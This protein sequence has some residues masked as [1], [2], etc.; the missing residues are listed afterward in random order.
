MGK[1]IIALDEGTTSCRSLVI[2]KHGTIVSSD[3]IEVSL[4]TPKQ[5]WVEQDALEIWSLQRTALIQS[6]NKAGINGSEIESIGI[7]NQRETVVV[8]DRMTGLPV[9]NAIIWQDRR[10]SKQCESILKEHGKLI[11]EKTGLIVSPYFSATKVRWI[12]ENVPNGVER[13]ERGELL[14]GTVNTWLIYKLTDSKSFLTDVTNASRTMLFNIHTNDWDDELLEIFK[15]PRA[16]LPTVKKNSDFFGKTYSSLISKTDNTRIP[17]TAS[18]GDQHASLFGHL[19]LD[20]GDAKVTYGTGCFILA[21]TGTKPII[22]EKGLLTTIAFAYG[23]DTFYA[24]EGSVMVAGAAL[25][26][27]KDDLKLIYSLEETEWYAN[28][29]VQQENLYVVPAFTGL[30]SPYWDSSARGAIIG[31]DFGTKREQLIT[32]FIK[33]I[34]YQANDVI[35]AMKSEMKLDFDS[36]KVDGGVIKNNFIMQFQADISQAEI[37]R[38]EN[39]EASAMGAAFLAGLYTGFW[40][41]IA[42]IKTTLS[43]FTT[44]HP[45]RKKE[46]VKKLLRGWKRAV[47]LTFNWLDEDTEA[48]D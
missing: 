7:T 45:M 20:E 39:V 9:Y 17:I 2:D 5:G 21:N 40:G 19:C 26:W 13:A 36:I 41:S 24:L 22:S 18:I 29:S 3:Q 23:V 16:C 43:D 32:A 15:I 4:Y 14:F 12:L 8:W 35:D 10:T 31:I 25:K 28:N 6:L 37:I 33:S 34:A 48:E 27:L 1:Y 30:G 42:E 46:E 44:K 47:A 38:P 11:K